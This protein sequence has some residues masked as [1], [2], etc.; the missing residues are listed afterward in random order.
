VRVVILD[1]YYPA[2][3]DDLYSTRPELSEQ[4]YR[5]QLGS[6]MEYC[7]GTSDAYS[8]HLQELGHQAVEIVAN[9]V[10]LQ[11]SWARENGIRLGLSW[12]RQMLSRVAARQIE[13]FD[14]DVVYVQDMGWMAPAE[15]RRL[16]SGGRR[17]IV[18]QIASPP[19]PVDHLRAYDLI[20][21]SFPHFVERFR[22]LGVWS[23]YFPL[24]FHERVLERLRA[25]GVSPDPS[26]DR[27]HA[28]AFVGGLSPNVHRA[29]TAMLERLAHSTPLEVWGYGVDAL[30]DESALR[31]RHHGEAWGLDMYRVLANA[32][33]VVNR[34]I[35]V[36]EGYANNM[37]LY[38]A[39]GVGAVVVTERA[40]N[41]SDL[42]EDGSEIAT[43]GEAE[44]LE[45]KVAHLLQHDDERLRIAGAGQ[46]R[47]LSTHSYRLRMA[48]LVRI[49]EQRLS[50]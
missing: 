31:A 33:I 28:V 1:T 15:L 18:G 30:P 46:T 32:R 25:G 23:E 4:P 10:P 36:A 49:L 20:L 35:D 27:P 16:R 2:F 6:L 48:E 19:P 41:L 45:S 21:T 42:F 43:Y 8:E 14:P 38:E 50:R 9:C 7:F 11:R 22:A 40:P 17:L 34:H 29:G 24:G 5:E 44:E 37:R 3:L 13:Q 12:R 39:T 47:T 26:A